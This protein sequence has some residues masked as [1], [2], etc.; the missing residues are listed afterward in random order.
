MV[1]DK[2]FATRRHVVLFGGDNL[3]LWLLHQFNMLKEGSEY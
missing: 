3:V 2:G 1:V